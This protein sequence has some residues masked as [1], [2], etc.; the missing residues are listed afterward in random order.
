METVF[1]N[2]RDPRRMQ[3]IMDAIPSSAI[4]PGGV[5]PTQIERW[6]TVASV[7]NFQ[8]VA[9]PDNGPAGLEH[10]QI[11]L[12]FGKKHLQSA[13]AA[14]TPRLLVNDTCKNQEQEM[15]TMQDNCYNLFLDFA[16]AALS[17]DLS[18]WEELVKLRLD[19]ELWNIANHNVY[20]A[21]YFVFFHADNN[22]IF[23]KFG[24]SCNSMLAHHVS[25]C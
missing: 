11:I 20:C 24:L 21:V 6:I 17:L 3:C 16:F 15:I 12:Q 8:L 9:S 22:T 10:E 2:S 25:E 18:N 23:Q 5:A 19:E 1:V 4:E 13:S 14:L 7:E